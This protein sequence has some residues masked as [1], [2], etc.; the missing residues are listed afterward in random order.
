MIPF[1]DRDRSK[2]ISISNVIIFMLLVDA[3]I[4]F[5]LKNKG[6]KQVDWCCLII[7]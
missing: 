2:K 5:I 1:N 4:S 3:L 6:N 7:H